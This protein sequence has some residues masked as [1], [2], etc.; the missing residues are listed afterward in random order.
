MRVLC[1][2]RRHPLPTSPIE[3][4]VVDRLCGTISPKPLPLHL[5]LDG[6]GREGVSADTDLSGAST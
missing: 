4:E 3:R 1:L 5:P 6:G 2:L